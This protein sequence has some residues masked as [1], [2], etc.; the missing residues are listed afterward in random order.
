MLRYALTQNSP[1]AI[2]YPRGE[3]D[4]STT[5]ATE[6]I[7][8][9]LRVLQ[10]GETVVF[11]SLGTIGQEVKR[12]LINHP[13]I[14]HIDLRTLKPWDNNVLKNALAH[15]TTAITIEEGAMRGGLRDTFCAWLQTNQIQLEVQSLGIHDSFVSHNSIAQLRHDAGI[16]AEAIQSYL[17]KYLIEKHK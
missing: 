6:I 16:S 9:Q 17:E 5:Q 11:L 10:S 3:E 12:A 7:S 15:Y 1:V 13:I 8:P 4:V 2:R 14:G